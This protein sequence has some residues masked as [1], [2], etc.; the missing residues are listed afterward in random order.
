MPR[1]ARKEGLRSQ[2]ASMKRDGILEAATRLM[3]ERGYHGC[4]M[5]ALAEDLGVTKPFIYY[6]F[7]DKAE[8]LGAICRTGADLSLAA[9]EACE[10]IDAGH[11]ERLRAFCLRLATIVISHGQYLAVYMRELTNLS[12]EYR[13]QIVKT[14]DEVDRRVARLIADGAKAGVFEV[15]DPLISAR[16]ITGMLS[17]MYMW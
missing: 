1:T 16:A 14:R 15:T 7:R 2:L 4:S 8:I 3:L 10:A 17:F 13:H 5:D 11:E 9:V 6:Q 12:G